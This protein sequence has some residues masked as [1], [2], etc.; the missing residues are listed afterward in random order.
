MLYYQSIFIHTDTVH[1]GVAVNDNA[2]YFLHTDK[3][4]ATVFLK[5]S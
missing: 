4:G 2:Q 1:F 3:V 5:S